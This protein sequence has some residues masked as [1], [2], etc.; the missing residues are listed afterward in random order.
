MSQLTFDES[1][2]EQLEAL[3]RTRDILRRRSLVY[4]A[5]APRPGERILDAGCGPGFYAAELP[6]KVGSGGSVVGVDVSAQMLAVA[7]RRCQ[8]HANAEF[9]EAPVTSLPIGEG[10]VD[11]ALCV[12]VLE[13]VQD[14]RLAISELYRV[15]RPGGRVVVWDVDWST[16]SWHSDDPERMR[17][18][19]DAWDDHLAHPALPRVL[20]ALLRA[21]GFVDV[22]AQGHSFVAPDY[23]PEAYG[24]ATIPVVERY[25]A[26]HD[27]VGPELAAAWAQEQRGLGDRGEFFFAC[28]QFGFAANRPD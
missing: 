18:V 21:A 15:V 17:L 7:A 2:V 24:V 28:I 4:E 11:R 22:E 8:G 16:V 1:L 14:V 5:L 13:Y 10:N 9:H 25:V 3:Y 26:G 27:A 12:Q 6:E 20:G 19:L 23:T